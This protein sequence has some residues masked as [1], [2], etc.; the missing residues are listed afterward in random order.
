[1]P[2]LATMLPGAGASLASTLDLTTSWTIY[3]VGTPGATN[4]ERMRAFWTGNVGKIKME[5]GGTGAARA[6]RL[7]SDGGYYV[8]IE[9]IY[10]NVGA[11]IRSSAG[12]AELVLDGRLSNTTATPCFRVTNS[13]NGGSIFT[14]ASGTQKHVIVGSDVNQSGTAAYTILDVYAGETTTGSGAKKLINARVNSSDMFSVDNAGTI[15]A[16]GAIRLNEPAATKA[17]DYT[18]LA[19]DF[20]VN[21]DT[22]AAARTLNLPA[23]ASVS[24]MIFFARVAAGANTLTFDPNGAELI[25]GGATKVGAAASIFWAIQSD[26]TGWKTIAGA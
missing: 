1:M 11:K 16:A 12:D 23:A 17:G 14:A 20:A 5:K 19:T 25:D 24:G 3:N 26:G 9:D 15:D 10:C 21:F 18:L 6:L 2:W 7:E 22:T 4:Y 13:G 8:E